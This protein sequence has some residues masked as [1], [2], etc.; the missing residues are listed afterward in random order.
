MLQLPLNVQ[1][2]DSAQFDNFFKADNLQLVSRLE[3]LLADSGDFIYI[4]GSPQTGKTH[5]A[6]ALCHAFNSR[7]LSAAY[8]PLD[9]PEFTA[10]ILDGMSFMDL[11]CID[12]LEKVLSI[13]EWEIALFDLYNRLKQDNKLLVIFSHASPSNLPIQLADLQSR[14]TAMEIYRLEGLNDSQKIE[15]FKT[16]ASNRGLDI[17]DEVIQFILSRYSRKL[18]DLMAILDKLDTSSIA[19]KRKVTIP[20]VKEILD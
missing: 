9:N 19:L 5:L 12:N 2:D 4:W 15:L 13:P 1:L 17:S 18:N 8:L 20:L 7:H 3:Q 6:Q 16:R 10:E 11:V 14:L